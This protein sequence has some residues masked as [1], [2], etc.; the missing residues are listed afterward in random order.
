MK[1]QDVIINELSLVGQ[2]KDVEAFAKEGLNVLYP[3]L[4]NIEDVRDVNLLKSSSLLS[5]LVTDK[6]DLQTILFTSSNRKFASIQGIKRH[7]YSQIKEPF[8]DSDPKQDLDSEYTFQEK[9][10]GLT[11]LAEAHA[12]NAILLS[13]QGGG[14]DKCPLEITQIAKNGEEDAKHIINITKTDQFL[15]EGYEAGV[16]SFEEY[17]RHTNWIKFDFSELDNKIGF[18]LI[19]K[20]LEGIFLSGFQKFDSLD[21]SDI[22]KDDGLDYKKFNK[23]KNT[24]DFFAEE[25][26]NKG[27]NK[28]R[29]DRAK[30]CF[31]YAENGIFHILRLDLTHRLSDLG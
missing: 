25:Y 19:A 11:S 28:F 12:R 23:N 20:E 6:L 21:W 30:R 17:V 16:I 31:G 24:K 29:I 5:K 4:L 2:F 8:W 9:S 13:Y 1:Q 22:P 15:E 14:Y 7:L 18:D 10:V 3:A 26:W 27:I